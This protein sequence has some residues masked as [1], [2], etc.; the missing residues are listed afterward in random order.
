MDTVTAM[1]WLSVSL[2]AL[3][4]VMALRLIE[5]ERENVQLHA[6]LNDPSGRLSPT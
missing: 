3:A 5:L 2:Q 4:A 6:R 1:L